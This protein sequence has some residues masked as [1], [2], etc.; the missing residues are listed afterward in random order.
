MKNLVFKN[1]IINALGI[2][3]SRILGLVRDILIALFLGAGL[4]SD[5]FFVALKMPAFF[6]RIFAEGAFGQSFLPNFVKAPKKGAFCVSI[7]IQFS[8]IVFLCCLLVSFFSSFFTKI[9]AFGFDQKTIDIASP[10]VAINFWYL[11]FIF[12]VTFFGAILNYKQKFFITSFSAA[13]FNLSIVIAAFFVDKNEP[14]KTLY[15][16]SYATVLSGLAQLILHLIILK[17]NPVIKAMILSIRLKKAKTKMKSFYGNFFH[18]VLGSSATQIS[19]L[20]DTT[21]ASFLISGSISYLYYANRVFQLPLALFAIALTQVSFPKILKHLKSEQE[22]LALKFMQRAMIFLSVLLL[23]SSIIGSVYSL[24]ICQLLF[25]RG[26]F[27]HSDSITTAYVL[28]AYLIG[29]LPFGLQ[30]LLSLWLY[31]KFKQKI[32]AFIAFKALFISFLCSVAFIFFIKDENLKVIGVAFSSSLSAFY[33]LGA[34]IKEFGFK[35]FFGLI[36]F[37][38][39]FLIIIALVIFTTMLYLTKPYIL[40]IFI[41]IYNRI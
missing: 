37:K 4:Y 12:L 36:S 33:L 8:S 32:A 1:F 7:M 26:N 14:L 38:I 24:E 28:I 16:F 15:Y 6:R 27:T 21:I 31:A 10:L 11:F 29:L 41:W 20:L 18:G 39:C 5:I 3:C 17:N 23:I 30:K 35:K 25:Q 19:S 34:N 9:F 13:L 40:N 22:N 2:L